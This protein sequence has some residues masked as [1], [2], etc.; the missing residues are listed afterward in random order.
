MAST[1]KHAADL[2]TLGERVLL[3]RRRKGLSQGDLAKLA[4]CDLSLISRIERGVKPS[5]SVEVLCRLALALDT[6]PND[7]LGWGKD[8]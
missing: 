1:L 6:S 7:L 3:A 5:L 4:P 2:P 8:V